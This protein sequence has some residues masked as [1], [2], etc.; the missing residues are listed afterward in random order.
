MVGAHS[1]DR[2]VAALVDVETTGLQPD[3][4]E[5]VEVAIV[6]FSFARDSGTVHAV[7]DQYVGLREP[8][9]P[10]SSGAAAM[11][12]LTPEAL[13]G[14]VFDD[15]RVHAL[16]R[17]AELIIAHN[18]AFDR[19]FLTRAYPVAE[20]KPWLCTMRDIDWR[21]RGAGLRS[22][23]ALLA[24]HGIAVERL[25]CA[26]ADCLATLQLLARPPRDGAQCSYLKEM[27]CRHGLQP[28]SGDGVPGRPG[29]RVAV[30]QRGP[31]GLGLSP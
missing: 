8:S 25:H 4:D 11:H 23:A 18:A 7:L 19:G 13:A 2:G 20:S 31:G 14:R 26:S 17:R 21:R 3:R 1:G 24:L 16:L 28:A 29:G 30:R 12:G 5:M 9:V 22:L 15:A 27:L 10:I 6:L